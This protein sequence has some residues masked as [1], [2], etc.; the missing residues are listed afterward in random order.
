MTLPPQLNDISSMTVASPCSVFYSNS[1]QGVSKGKQVWNRSWT[2]VQQPT[3]I[4]RFCHLC[5]FPETTAA[6]GE[7]NPIP[8]EIWVTGG[9]RESKKKKKTF[10]GQSVRGGVETWD[11]EWC[12]DSNSWMNTGQ[13][14][15]LVRLHHHQLLTCKW[16]S[17][18]DCRESPL[19]Q[20]IYQQEKK[21]R[22]IHEYMWSLPRSVNINN[23]TMPA[24]Q[25]V[26]YDFKQTLSLLDVT[27]QKTGQTIRLR[28]HCHPLNAT[29]R[30]NRAEIEVRQCKDSRC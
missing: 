6:R 28:S 11:G 23:V 16:F 9:F 10:S 30:K 27:V 12:V 2:Q 7:W 15:K 14:D 24:A 1:E 4:Q 13:R 3:G 22:T 19:L 26:Q 29:A 25:I 21:E 5:N 20:D 8:T 17:L 18:F